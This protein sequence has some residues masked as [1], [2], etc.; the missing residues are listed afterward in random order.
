[1]TAST[2]P[3]AKLPID[4][5]Q[6]RQ[7]WKAL[8]KL[9]YVYEIRCIE[10]TLHGD[11][12]PYDK[13][14]TINGY[15]NDGEKLITAL[16]Q[17]AS[18]AGIYIIP[19]P[20]QPAL[21]AHTNNRFRDKKTKCAQ[22][23]EI[24]ARHLMLLDAD[25]ER[26]GGIKGIPT[27]EAESKVAADFA[28]TVRNWLIEHGWSEPID[29]D[30]GN[31]RY[32]GI[33]IDLPADDNGLV[34]RVLKGLA[35]QLDTKAIHIDQTTYNQARLMRLPGTWNCKGDGTEDRQHRIARVV[36]IPDETHPVPVEQLEAITI[37]VEQER[38]KQEQKTINKSGPYKKDKQPPDYLDEW[39]VAFG[40][41]QL[42]NGGW[43]WQLEE[44]PFCHNSDHNAFVYVASNGKF[45]FK[46]SHN[47]CTGRD[48]QAFR[49]HFEPTAYDKRDAWSGT[50]TYSPVQ[51]HSSNGNGYHQDPIDSL[52]E[53]IQQ[54]IQGIWTKPKSDGKRE[55]VPHKVELKKI[56]EYL[57]MNE[58]GDGKLFAEA[59]N[60]LVCYDHS[61]KSW[62]VWKEHHWKK[63]TTGKIKQLVSGYLGSIY[64]KARGDIHKQMVDIQL[65]IQQLEKESGAEGKIIKLKTKLGYLEALM[66]ELEKRARSLRAAKRM[67]NVLTFAM[68]EHNVGI[69][70]D[71]WDSDPWLL[72]V[73]NG[74]V[75][76]RT[77][78]CRDGY[79]IDYIRSV[80]PTMWTGI[81][82][83]CLR[84]ERF[85]QEIFEV[86]PEAQLQK[87][88]DGKYNEL[89]KEEQ[90]NITE[91]HRKK[92]IGFLQ[93]LFG[94]SI[95]GL[96]TEAIFPLLYGE[97]GRNGKDTLFTI[98]KTVLGLAIA[99]AISN[100]VFISADKGRAAGSATPHLTDLQGKRIVWGS[101]TKQGDRINVSQIKQLTGGGSI[102]ARPP[103]GF[104]YTF[105]PTH[106][107]FLMTNY[108]PHADARDKA[109][110][111][112]ACLIEFNMRFV[113]KP[114]E[115]TNERAKDTALPRELETE[116]SGILA[117]LVRGC[118]D[119]Q[120]QRLNRPEIVEVSTESYRASE[121]NIQQFI[122]ECCVLGENY[123]VG[124][125]ELY[126]AYTE[127]CDGNRIS[128]LNGKLFGEDIS[129]RF[130]KQRVTRG[131]VYKKV[132][133]LPDDNNIPPKSTI[134]QGT[135]DLSSSNTEECRDNV[136]YTSPPKAAPEDSL[137]HLEDQAYVGYV[138]TFQE[139]PYSTP[140]ECSIDPLYG[141]T[142][143]TIHKDNLETA[144]KE[145]V[146]PDEATMYGEDNPT[147]PYIDP[148]LYS[149]AAF[150]DVGK[151]HGYPEV[152]ELELKSGIMG[153]NS[154]SLSHRLR[155]P[156]VI[157][158][159]GG[160]Q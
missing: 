78:E 38:Q 26:E 80:S 36:S 156:D 151:K 85:L 159:L 44:C 21:L 137:G 131:Y 73:K 155:I 47:S 1:M 62:Y 96:S 57:D 12:L 30:S 67:N 97:E 154:F 71:I 72:G 128:R 147:S 9:G 31:G 53:E 49:L 114:K 5:Q 63:D 29:I 54:N 28:Q 32:L 108:K 109:F 103:Y 149:M 35:Q 136:G 138:G 117:W 4:V 110:W 130:E 124:A 123:H 7:A 64:L 98:L 106:T 153:W 50:S 22:D 74:V 91:K 76:L 15:F 79:P 66:G 77:G 2:T 40:S 100:D 92:L 6:V 88:T 52:I 141:N 75:D 20:C 134:H 60:G 55:F 56:I 142:I 23:D 83:P 43:K 86:L 160:V 81:N 11:R 102:S 94:Y 42:Y 61:E 68:S 152:S 143:H 126:K 48:W 105:E 58:Y 125:S 113:D 70:G 39:N 69:T 93:R 144:L 46:C 121:D 33:V 17:I 19:N 90:E 146:E 112:R 25:P 87:L 158:R 95:A 139:V 118:L 24:V 127:W 116:A 82:T 101:E 122:D 111:S 37:S 8:T 14:R 115:D 140:R 133:L 129:K 34:Q 16:Q 27:T 104:Q 89:P 99:N 13:P 3:R 10:A 84:F 107:L 65:E 59:F 132:G 157:A 145:P 148:T 51:E 45:G 41:Q 120:K 135:F 150:W 119:Y 18:A